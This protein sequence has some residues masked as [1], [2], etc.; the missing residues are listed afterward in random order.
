MPVKYPNENNPQCA[1][2]EEMQ[3]KATPS[4]DMIEVHT[5]PE[6]KAITDSGACV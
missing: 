4:I 3:D 6:K 5:T 2:L 1:Y